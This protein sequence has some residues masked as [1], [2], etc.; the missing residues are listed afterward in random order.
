LVNQP[1]LKVDG[2]R[3]GYGR[4]T[5]LWDVAFE[6]PA[7]QVVTLLGSN[8]AGKTTTLRTLSG[9]LGATAGTVY[10]DGHEITRSRSD[11]RVE[12]GIVH[13]P[14]G[15]QLWPRMSVEDN[16]LLGA[17]LPRARASRDESLERLYRLFPRL[18]ERRRQAAGTLSGGERQMCAL[19][20][21]LMSLPRLLML[22][23]PSLGLAPRLVL[24]TFE[25]L[26]RLRAEEGLTVLLV[27]QSVAQA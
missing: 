21:G 23:E 17:Y 9:L 5:A 13:V 6:V 19:A 22:D 11:Q 27:E 3:A 25:T 20:R 14:E 10:F 18:K 7:G 15:R 24:E 26:R 12:L 1:L 8:G 2:L 4:V 16:L